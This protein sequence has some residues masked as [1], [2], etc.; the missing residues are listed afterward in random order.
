MPLFSL[1]SCS[2]Q[3]ARRGAKSAMISETLAGGDCLNT[4]CVPSK[5]IIRSARAVSEVKRAAEFG[6]VFKEGN[7]DFTVDFAA[8]MKRVRMMRAKIAP[9]D[10]HKVSEEAGTHVYQ[11]RGRLTSPTT[12]E[13][14]G[15]T[16]QFKK[17]VLA[18]GGRPAIPS[19]IEGLVKG[20]TPYTTS[21]TLFNLEE[22]PPRMVVLG[23][24]VVAL[25]MA[26]TFSLLGSNVSVI[27]RSSRLFA[28]KHGDAEAATILQSSLEHDGVTF[29]HNT[30][31]SKVTTLR[32]GSEGSSNKKR[33]RDDGTEEDDESSTSYFPLMK[34]T[35][36]NGGELECECFLIAAGRLA[37][38]EDLGLE[39]GNVEYEIGKGI[40]INDLVES[41]SNPN[42]YAIG[43]CAAGVPRLTHM[44]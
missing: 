28:S 30:K 6:I 2:L 41:V 33:K 16:L 38:V 27:N 35:L 44:R 43:D 32:Q 22:L 24:G 3:S 13:V 19:N 37:N 29:Y 34:L 20:E 40:K 31:I 14:N 17:C 11:G 18:T 21:E 8:V 36:D 25:E 9:V 26:Q 7:G 39:E 10:G 23:G 4:G 15:I 5:A 12:V 1:P 42:V